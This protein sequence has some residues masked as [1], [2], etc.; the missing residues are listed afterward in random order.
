MRRVEF[1]HLSSKLGSKR[2]RFLGVKVAVVFRQ[3]SMGNQRHFAGITTEYS[4]TVD[5]VEMMLFVGAGL[6]A[7]VTYFA[8]IAAVEC[9]FASIGDRVV[10]KDGERCSPRIIFVGL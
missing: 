1:R 10:V 9:E 4:L 2:R 6:E 5:F 7:V 8:E 3:I